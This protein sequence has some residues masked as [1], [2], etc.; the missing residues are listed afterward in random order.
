M[1]NVING[2]IR[3]SWWQNPAYKNILPLSV[4]DISRTN[5]SVMVVIACYILLWALFILFSIE[6]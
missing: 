5:N 4:R 1:L 6:S 2:K 3:R